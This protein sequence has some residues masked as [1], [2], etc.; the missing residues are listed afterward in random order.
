MSKYPQLTLR[1]LMFGVLFIGL[2][3]AGLFAGGVMASL[4]LGGA[5][6][7]TTAFAIIALVG[8]D[9]P[10]AAAVGFFVVVIAYAASILAVSSPELDPYEGK[11]PTTKLIQPAF[12]LVVRSEWINVVTGEPIPDFDP[13][14]PGPYGAI[15]PA[16]P[17][18]GLKETPDRTTFMSV[19]HTFLAIIFGYI[20]MKFAGYV[21][22]RQ[23]ALVK[24]TD[25]D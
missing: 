3:C 5:L 2:G 14:N 10:R 23:N 20:G 11:L 25:A 22:R 4:F 6:I 21:Y 7:V 12:R 13:S 17:P 9:E 1:E 15:G 19:A 24:A 16:G 18:V 8:R